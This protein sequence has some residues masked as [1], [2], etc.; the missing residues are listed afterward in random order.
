MSSIA[1]K[2]IHGIIWSA[3]ERFSLQGVQFFIGIVLARLLSPSDFGMIGM[4]SI[5]MSVSQ[6]LI[7]CGFSNALIRLKKASSKDYGT[8]FLVNFSISV[9][10][11]FVLFCVAPFVAS[12]YKMPELQPVMRVFAVTL[13][14]NALFTIH[15]VRL[16]RN[17]DFK[18]QS[19]ISFCAALFSGILGI[20][21]AYKG[22]GVWSL[23][24][25][26]VCNSLL[27]F[28]LLVAGLKWFPSFVFSKE[29]FRSLFGFGSKLLVASIISSIYS[30]LYN[31][32]IGKQYSASNLGFYTRAESLGNFP[33]Q[34]VSGILSRVTFP[35][36]SQLQDDCKRLRSIYVKY[37]QISCFVVF[38]LMMG[39]AALA[40]P[41]II[42]LLGEKWMTSVLLLQILCFALMLDPIC[43]I[44]LNLL[45]V[46]GRSDLV[47]KL[48]IIKK[49]IAV[50]ILVL[51]LPFGL[52]G[53]CTGRAIYGVVAT[54]L[55]MTYTKSF[56]D[57]S[58]L[59]QVKLILPSMLLSFLMAGA[60][61]S[62]TLMDLNYGILLI[63][64][65]L[66]GMVLYLGIAKLL[67]MES[68]EQLLNIAKSKIKA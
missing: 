43:S 56:I 41:L 29:S 66:V 13:I 14:I 38:P 2:S 33:S 28:V 49:T 37:L 36:L 45:Y 3:V 30:N 46:K 20:V 4:L 55:N 19:K 54:T 5:F 48:E 12:F 7:D 58:I 23:V 35:I 39:L 10:I 40:K 67:H 18:T 6:T 52:V 60:S 42:L 22:F 21:L 47:L 62:V 9:L 44:N 57:L 16:T 1:S 65:I 64:G 32:V 61:Y 51:S 25:Q 17:V 11:F 59:G 68:M 50:I 31:I 15:K 26:A 53:L 24:Y 8:A 27:N 63:L 34:N